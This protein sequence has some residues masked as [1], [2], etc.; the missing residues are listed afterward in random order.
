M[1]RFVAIW[2]CHL[3]AD[4]W[5]RN[6]PRLKGKPFMRLSEWYGRAKAHPVSFARLFLTKMKVVATQDLINLNDGA[7]VRVYAKD[8]ALR[9][10]FVL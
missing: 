10:V 7:F 1:G 5:V 4:R 6:E 2:F 9:E 3:R 8:L